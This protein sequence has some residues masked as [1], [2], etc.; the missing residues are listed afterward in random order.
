MDYQRIYSAFI[1]HRKS[2]ADSLEGY[3]ENHHIIPRA[4]GGSDD[5]ENLI[6]LTARDHY[7]AHCCLAKIHG[8]KM[9]SALFAIAHMAKSNASW[10]YFCR[11]RMVEASRKQA[12]RRRSADMKE[13]WGSGSFE[14]ARVYEPWSEERRA[15]VSAKLRGRP[16]DPAS[17]KRAVRSRMEKAPRFMFRHEDGRQFNGPATDFVAHSGLSQ[18]LVSYLTRGKIR[19]AKGWHLEGTDLRLIRNRNPIVY[20]FYHADG[21]VFSGTCYEFRTSIPG[22]DSGSLSKM[23]AGKLKTIKGWRVSDG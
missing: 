5:A 2:L 12:A 3:T 1:A 17:I 7:F 14:R 8:G 21:R 11:R 4:L 18:S 10:E 13:R 9:W 19:I 22:I 6:R 15:R 23:I 20:R 16:A